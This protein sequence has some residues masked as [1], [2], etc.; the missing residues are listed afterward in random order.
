VQ[1][2]AGR[3]KH[4]LGEAQMRHRLDRELDLLFS[5][6]G[7]EVYQRVRAS[8]PVDAS[9]VVRDLVDRIASVE[10]ERAEHERAQRG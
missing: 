5:E 1:D 6:L 3:L 4:E 9:V 2:A 8:E 7:I 10:R